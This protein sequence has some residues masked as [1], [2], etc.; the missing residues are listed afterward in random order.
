MGLL[1]WAAVAAGGAPFAAGASW[2]RTACASAAVAD[3][4][5]VCAAYVD[6]PTATLNALFFAAYVV[7]L[8]VH[9]L[10]VR[11]TWLV[12]PY[13]TLMPLSIHAYYASHP[14]AAWGGRAY[15][16]TALLYAW[17][18]RLSWNY[19]RRERFSAGGREDWRLAD[20]RRDLGRFWWAAS[21]PVAYVSQQGM[22]V[23]LCLPL[24]DV[25]LAHA[26]PRPLG[27]WDACCVAAAVAG[28]ALARAADDALHAFTRTRTAPGALLTTGVWRLCRHPNHLGEMVWWSALAGLATCASGH[29]TPS[30]LGCLFNHACDA[31]VTVPLIDRRLALRRDRVRAYVRYA[32]STPQLV[33]TRASVRAWLRGAREA[34]D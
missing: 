26:P 18:A 25:F 17:S 32:A 29:A 20:M 22:L 34:A 5:W 3:G 15:V 31:G 21:L 4:D 16:A 2:L 8:W 12:D 19:W 10:L 14:S 13:W 6:H 30:A 7:P 1:A 24:R 27:A 33:P 23:G 9:S 28:L 11:S